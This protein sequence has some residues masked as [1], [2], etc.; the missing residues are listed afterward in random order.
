M[1]QYKA[2]APSTHNASLVCV[3][4]EARGRVVPLVREI[5]PPGA[6]RAVATRASAAC[7][8]FSLGRR[9]VALSPEQPSEG[10]C[11]FSYKARV[12]VAAVGLWM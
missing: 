3:T 4:S 2:R 5:G 7:A 9:S 12:E 8:A 10:A 1:Y 11:R 6:A